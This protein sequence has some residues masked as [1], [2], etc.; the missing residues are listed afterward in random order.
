MLDAYASQPH[1]AAHMR[2]VWEAL[3]AEVRGVWHRRPPRD[4][5]PPILVAGAI[6]VRQVRRRQV[7]Y[8]EHGAGQSYDGDPRVRDQG[9]GYSGG[10]GLDR[11]V[12]FLCPSEQVA[13]R[14]RRRYPA[15]PAAVVGCPRL[16]RW[17]AA[18]ASGAL[19]TGPAP[20]GAGPVVAVT[21]HWPCGLCPETRWAFPWYRRHLAGLVDDV[22][23]A[24]GEVIGHA[25]PKAYAH[26]VSTWC[27]LGV[28]PIPD[29][30]VVLERADLFIGDNTSALP[31]AAAA[32][33]PLVWMSAPWYRRD[34]EH[35]GRFWTWPQGQ[36]RVGNGDELI[37]RW[38]EALLDPPH[39][40][41]A[42]EAMVGTIYA[43]RDGSAAARAA[44]A[45][46]KVLCNAP[47]Q[48]D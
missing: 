45:I 37:E 3:P 42:R 39:V 8:L 23:A 2:P 10:P 27:G 5:G 21:F 6:D 38:H 48:T 20:G 46:I 29:L 44:A 26:L 30:D 14:W 34:V 35:G 17:H 43:H 13:E 22:R 1:Y 41:A 15:T 47:S 40:R 7:V 31:E 9:V 24:G 36:V 16:D 28:R 4:E 19:S 12:L 32:G 33:I 18:G 25:H 11:A